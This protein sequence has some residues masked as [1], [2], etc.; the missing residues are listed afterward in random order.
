MHTGNITRVEVIDENGRAYVRVGVKVEVQ[1]QDDGATLKVFVGARDNS[2]VDKET[3]TRMLAK[4][5]D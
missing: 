1:V 3:Y 2:E 5:M 4:L